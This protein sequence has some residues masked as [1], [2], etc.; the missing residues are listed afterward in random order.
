MDGF[1]DRSD[2][3]SGP[4][5]V[6]ETGLRRFRQDSAMIPTFSKISSVMIETPLDGTGQP[7]KM[8]RFQVSWVR[9]LGSA[10][11]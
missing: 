2:A 4:Y 9:D 7:D 1:E 6:S 3:S 5:R 11:S 10:A 8:V